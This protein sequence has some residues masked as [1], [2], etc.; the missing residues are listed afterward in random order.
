MFF[1]EYRHT[2]DN[3]G[4]ITLPAAFREAF[5][6]GLFINKH[7]DKSLAVYTRAEWQRILDDMSNLNDRQSISRQYLRVFY[8]G[9][10]ADNLDKQGRIQLGQNLI[11]H[12]NLEKDV[13]IIGVGTHLEIW[14]TQNWEEYSA[15]AESDYEEIAEKL[16]ER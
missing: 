1:G 15:T 5:S 7:L 14:S 8:S 13:T 12:A 10:L 16:P 9:V 6:D 2:L 4:R 11:N 3:K